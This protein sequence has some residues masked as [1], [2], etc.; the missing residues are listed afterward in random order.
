MS[1]KTVAVVFLLFACSFGQIAVVS[2]K[3]PSFPQHADSV[4]FVQI[5]KNDS[6]RTTL[7][8]TWLKDCISSIDT[9]IHYADAVRLHRKEISGCSEK[10]RFDSFFVFYENKQRVMTVF[11]S[12]K[13]YGAGMLDCKKD[14]YPFVVVFKPEFSRK[15][16][17]TAA[18]TH[19]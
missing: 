13:S 12:C 16:R 9:I 18:H 1:Y 7:P 19:G 5:H 15:I 2:G 10:K 4:C 3:A 6:L 8:V 17:R 14:K 11:F